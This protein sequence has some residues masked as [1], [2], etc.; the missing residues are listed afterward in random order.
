MVFPRDAV[1]LYLLCWN[2]NIYSFNVE[3]AISHPRILHL[4]L[5]TSS[6]GISIEIDSEARKSTT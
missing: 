3:R 5:I 1:L 4:R 2:V 6:Y